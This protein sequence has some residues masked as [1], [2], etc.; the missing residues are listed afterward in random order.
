MGS[1]QGA[2]TDANS[3]VGP[4]HRKQ[5]TPAKALDWSRGRVMLP[6]ARKQMVET[7]QGYSPKPV[8]ATSLRGKGGEGG[9]R[10]Q[11]Y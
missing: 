11:H 6:F 3:W 10:P 5:G 9:R 4:P 8:T 7:P 1:R 2:P